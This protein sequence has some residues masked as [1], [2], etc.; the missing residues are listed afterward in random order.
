LTQPAAIQPQKSG[1]SEIS[2]R[3]L[4]FSV[5]LAGANDADDMSD[6]TDLLVALFMVQ[7]QVQGQVFFSQQ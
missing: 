5:S 3:N 6:D 7:Y 1:S 2:R 4:G